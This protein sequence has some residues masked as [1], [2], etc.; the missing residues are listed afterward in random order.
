MLCGAMDTACTLSYSPVVH[1]SEYCICDTRADEE[2]CVCMSMRVG[3][4]HCCV[5]SHH[6]CILYAVMTEVVLGIGQCQY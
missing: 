6:T 4:F 2:T 1:D 5:K 3:E